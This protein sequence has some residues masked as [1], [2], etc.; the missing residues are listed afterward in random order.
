LLKHTFLHVP[1]VGPATEQRLWEYGV[2]DWDCALT[3]LP[4]QLRGR[5]LESLPRTIRESERALARHDARF[6][7]E[8]MPAKHHW[9]LYPAFRN[10]VAFLDIETTGLS[11]SHD[12]ITTI[13]VYDDREIHTFVRGR[14]LD[15]F[16]RHIGSYRLL[17]TYNGRC[18]D[19][20]FIEA[21][22]PGLRLDQPHIDLR[23]LLGSLGY[24]GG[25]KGCERAM[26]LAREPGLV[27]VDGFMAVKLWRAHERGDRRAL[28]ALLRYNI[29]DVVNLQWLMG[30][31]YN[32]TIARLPIGV[33]KIEVAPRPAV[34]RPFDP[35]IIEELSGEVRD[36]RGNV[37]RSGAACPGKPRACRR[38]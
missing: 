27:E 26:G 8:R 24:H 25:L 31:A 34:D 22:F 16:P 17:V 32:M 19:V 35:S 6:F 20:P 9:R 33:A 15:E 3:E 11:S 21:Q 28:P 2:L 13:A 30:T 36:F 1:R 37:A 18:F 10:G 14:N 12:D 38:T 23:Y 29:E 5:Y 7:A 4:G